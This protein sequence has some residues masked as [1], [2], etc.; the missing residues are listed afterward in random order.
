MLK[1]DIW[2]DNFCHIRY[3]SVDYYNH[4]ALALNGAGTHGGLLC[5]YYIPDQWRLGDE[6]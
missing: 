4:V 3:I 2:W 6:E 5:V 1:Y